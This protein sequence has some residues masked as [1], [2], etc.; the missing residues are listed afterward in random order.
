MFRSSFV[1][2][3][4]ST[5]SFTIVCNLDLLD[6]WVWDIMEGGRAARETGRGSFDMLGVSAAAAAMRQPSLR[7]MLLRFWRLSL[8]SA[9][10]LDQFCVID[11]LLR[12]VLFVVLPTAIHAAS[13]LLHQVQAAA[14]LVIDQL[15]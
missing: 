9:G 5:L 13:R 14:S 11:E 7:I 8:R 3:S 6:F 15:P 10:M 2:V 1:F 12:P 4:S